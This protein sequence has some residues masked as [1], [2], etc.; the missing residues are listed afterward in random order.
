MAQ[1]SRASLRQCTLLEGSPKQ[2]HKSYSQKYNLSVVEFWHSH[3]KNVYRTAQHFYV[4]RKMVQHW[5]KDEERIKASR[6]EA[7]Q[8]KYYRRGEHP[9]ISIAS[10]VNYV[11]GG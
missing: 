7:K 6:K 4:D 3:E 2:Q 11:V 8:V 1:A 9:D 10:T 5:V